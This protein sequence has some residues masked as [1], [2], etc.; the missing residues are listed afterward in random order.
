[1]SVADIMLGRAGFI[2]T[3]SGIY[4]I[5][6]AGDIL[7]A[8]ETVAGAALSEAPLN[9]MVKAGLGVVTKGIDQV[10]I[11]RASGRERV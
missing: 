2:E 1:M 11:G 3:K 5:V 6:I 7:Q 8:V 9:I 10:K 4:E